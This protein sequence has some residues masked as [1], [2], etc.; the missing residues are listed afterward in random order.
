MRKTKQKKKFSFLL[1]GIFFSS[2]G[3]GLEWN[4][5]NISLKTSLT[6]VICNIDDVTKNAVT[7]ELKIGQQFV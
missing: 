7:M 1:V 2:F 6:N 3:F 5:L 4:G